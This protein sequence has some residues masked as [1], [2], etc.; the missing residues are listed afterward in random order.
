MGGGGRLEGFVASLGLETE[1]VPKVVGTFVCCKYVT[2][3]AGIVLGVRY[4]PLRRLLLPRWQ[5]AIFQAAPLVKRQRS[6][7]LQIW[8]GARRSPP[9]RSLPK[10]SVDVLSLRRFTASFEQR[11]ID[12][13][14]SHTARTVVRKLKSP[15]PQRR[16]LSARVGDARRHVSKHWR[17]ASLAISSAS[18]GAAA[19]ARA[20]RSQAFAMSAGFRS[21]VVRSRA[22][23]ISAGFRNRAF[24][25]SN[26]LRSRA[27]GKLLRFQRL[28]QRHRLHRQK[29]LAQLRASSA[30]MQ[31]YGWASAKY[32]KYADKI[33]ALAKKSWAGRFFSS[34]LGMRPQGLAL[35]FAEGTILF[36]LSSPVVLPLQLWALVSFFK[37]QRLKT[38]LASAPAS[39]DEGICCE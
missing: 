25:I 39:C 6:R 3:G 5:S 21:R 7:L 22:F 24:A 17:E 13:A 11:T 14:A 29:Q 37:H 38:F 16:R 36:K 18:A 35:G 30:P 9:P 26:H 19:G 32:W 27:S 8:E 20:M 33:E 15:T 31:W 23:A 2:W 28:V 34:R 10:P 12:A 4:K 1:D